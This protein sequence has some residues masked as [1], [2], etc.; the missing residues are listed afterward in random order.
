VPINF[1]VY[2]TNEED[3]WSSAT[4]RAWKRMEGLLKETRVQVEALGARYAVVSIASSYMLGGADELALMLESYPD[5]ERTDW[6]LEYPETRLAELCRKNG[7]LYKSL[8]DSFRAAIA[9]EGALLHWKYEH[10]WAPAGHDKAAQE[11]SSF[12]LE[13]E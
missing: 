2:S 12:I 8:L 10:H 5:M 1:L 4:E 11:I 3:S 9:E 13:Q 7:I 6:D